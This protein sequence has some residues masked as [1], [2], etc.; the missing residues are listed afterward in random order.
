MKKALK[1]W[2]ELYMHFKHYEYKYGYI[3]WKQGK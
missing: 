1:H 2:D 3:K